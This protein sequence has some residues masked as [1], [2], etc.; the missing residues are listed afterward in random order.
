MDVL[1]E[2]TTLPESVRITPNFQDEVIIANFPD[3]LTVE[4]QELFP[5]YDELCCT[6]EKFGN[7]NAI[8]E[9]KK[10]EKEFKP[11]DPSPRTDFE[12]QAEFRLTRR[13]HTDKFA[14]SYGLRVIAANERAAEHGIATLK[15][16]LT[17]LQERD[18][19][20]SKLIGAEVPHSFARQVIA[21]EIARLIEFKEKMIQARAELRPQ[22]EGR[23]PID[24]FHW[25]SPPAIVAEVFAL[26][27]KG[28]LKAGKKKNAKPVAQEA[29]K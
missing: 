19:E 14:R 4:L 12:I 10:R 21:A 26:I 29:A 20:D 16:V 2:I 25:Q 9:R 13:F 22:L 27:R 17:R 8:A 7:G 15:P 28:E 5:I 11:G 6:R 3:D 23:S 24:R 18:A 1:P